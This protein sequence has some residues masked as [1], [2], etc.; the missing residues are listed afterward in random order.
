ME[1]QQLRHFLAAV[2]HGNIGKAAEDQNIT[3]SGL[4]RS[5]LNLERQLGLTLLKRNPRG[6]EPT[7][8]GRSLIPHAEATLNKV[9]RAV[10]ELESLSRLQTGTVSIGITL[11]YS[12]YFVPEILF[13][14]LTDHPGIQVQVESGAYVDLVER[15]RRAELDLVF[16][17]IAMDVQHSDFQTE[18]LFVTRSIIVARPDHPLVGRRKVN[19]ADL[20]SA[21]WAMLSGEGFQKAFANHFYL[22]SAAV[23][24]QVFK[25]NSLALLKR[26]ISSRALLTVLPREIVADELARGSLAQVRADTPADFA[27]AGLAMRTDGVVTPAME[28]VMER[29]RFHARKY[30][31]SAGR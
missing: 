29:I 9:K 4:S 2:R 12:H 24:H 21:E 25:T 31:A 19:V 1:L 18:E 26:V 5:I 7:P 28:R 17:L 10:S 23:P 3:Q 13:E 11:N 15:L 16:G 22:R 14:L 8:F 27:R 6:V 20:S 30:P